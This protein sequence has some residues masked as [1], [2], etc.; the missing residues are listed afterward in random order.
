[1]IFFKEKEM[2]HEVDGTKTSFNKSEGVL[3]SQFSRPTTPPSESGS[4]NEQK[5][6]KYNFDLKN[7]FLPEYLEEAS[8][9]DWSENAKLFQ[10]FEDWISMIRTLREARFLKSVIITE[11]EK[12]VAAAAAAAEVTETSLSNSPYSNG[13]PPAKKVALMKKPT[14]IE[15]SRNPI[16]LEAQLSLLSSEK[17][18]DSSYVR[19]TFSENL[20]TAAKIRKALISWDLSAI[21][22]FPKLKEVIETAPSKEEAGAPCL[23]M[24][25]RVFFVFDRDVITIGRHKEIEGEVESIPDIDLAE[26]FGELCRKITSHLHA[27][28]TCKNKLTNKY[29]LYVNGRNGLYVDGFHR[30]QGESIP[31]KNGMQ[32]A[33]GLLSFEY[34]DLS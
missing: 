31:L 34:V 12:A 23:T 3:P 21:E 28:I 25:G 19:N 4:S 7:I 18:L 5:N 27:T 22:A 29:V 8:K 33:I 30:V 10:Q 32:I 13:T 16:L 2:I 9:K 15:P 17:D 24:C 11:K 26:L 14:P 1:M 6:K 20:I